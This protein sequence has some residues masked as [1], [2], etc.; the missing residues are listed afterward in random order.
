[1]QG[2]CE[3]KKDKWGSVRYKQQYIC[4]AEIKSRIKGALR[5]EART[6]REDPVY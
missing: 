1:M 2:K 5:S 3:E 4:S 6:G